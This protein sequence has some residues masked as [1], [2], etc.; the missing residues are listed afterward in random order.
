VLLS[1]TRFLELQY[2][3]VIIPIIVGCVYHGMYLWT[4]SVM[5]LICVVLRRF[6]HEQR[7][8]YIIIDDTIHV[9]WSSLLLTC[10]LLLL[11][12]VVIVTLSN[13]IN[14]AVLLGPANPS[15]VI[16]F[17]AYCFPLR[18]FQLSKQPVKRSFN[19]LLICLVT[20]GDQIE[21]TIALR[22]ED[23]IT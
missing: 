17:L 15:T 16:P 5:H 23:M 21:V 3:W 1:P 18:P 6:W 19:R 4:K 10:K 20:R 8:G 11:Y 7:S 9:T 2:N 22:L 13:I 14:H 12:I